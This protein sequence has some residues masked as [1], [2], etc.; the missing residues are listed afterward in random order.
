MIKYVTITILYHIFL[1]SDK[2]KDHDHKNNF[3]RVDNHRKAAA[4]KARLL[5]EK[6]LNQSLNN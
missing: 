3:L 6:T 2:N 1:L 4:E 5:E